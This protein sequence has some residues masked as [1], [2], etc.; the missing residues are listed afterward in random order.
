MLSARGP[1]KKIM[2]WVY[3]RLVE[4][5]HGV[6][7]TA[8]RLDFWF[9][10]LRREQRDGIHNRPKAIFKEREVESLD[11]G[12]GVELLADDCLLFGVSAGRASKHPLV[13]VPL[14]T[15]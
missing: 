3:E 7:L 13:N 15:R 10:I 9:C 11:S 2:D 1:P 4:G 6:E 14:I 5:E 12:S 8:K